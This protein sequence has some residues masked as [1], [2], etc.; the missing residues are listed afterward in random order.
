MFLNF[1]RLLLRL[2]NKC[3]TSV[4]KGGFRKFGDKSVIRPPASIHGERLI[5]IGNKVFIGADCWLLALDGENRINEEP[6]I[7]IGDGCSF[8]G[9]S[10]LTAVSSLKV[11]NNVL[12][13][14]NVHVSDH[15]HEFS[16][17]DNPIMRQGITSG[18]PVEICDGAWIG[19]G[20]VICPGVR[21]GQNSV[22]GANSVVRADVPDFC[23][24][25]GVPARVIRRIDVSTRPD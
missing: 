24:A 9:A 10:T 19:Q 8:G 18:R 1:Y 14:R 15:T 23:V 13:G 16:D 22:I 5:E 7:S 20:V 2:R 4:I 12:F 25:A 6:V 21:V 3:F 17:T 11:G